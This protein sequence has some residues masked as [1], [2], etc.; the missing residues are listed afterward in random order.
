L[1]IFGVLVLLVSGAGQMHVPIMAL[2]ENP[3]SL[4][5]ENLPEYA[6]RTVLRMFAAITLSLIFTFIFATI[7][8]KSR[9]AEMIM[10]PML[11]I[12]QSVPV[13]GFISFTVLFFLYLFPG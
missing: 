10:I 13:L 8:A 9:R 3:I 5:P 7:A 2:E 4:D 1:L 6:L 12:L 11:D